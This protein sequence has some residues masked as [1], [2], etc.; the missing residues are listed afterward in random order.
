M[1][2][3]AQ[4]HRQRARAHALISCVAHGSGII[5]TNFRGAPTMIITGVR[6]CFVVVQYGSAGSC[7]KFR[8]VFDKFRGKLLHVPLALIRLGVQL[9]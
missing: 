6:Y 4:L 8:V 2:H 9:G 7:V 5:E 1:S 3:A